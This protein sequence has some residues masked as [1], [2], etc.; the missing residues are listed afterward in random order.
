MSD[1]TARA[2]AL[3]NLLQTHRHWT[4]QELAERLGV[5]RRTLRRDV[6]R[7]RDL[8]YR[9]GSAPGL[10][11]G[12]RLEPGGVVP[13]LLLTDDEA[14]AMAAGLRLAAT[15]RLT[16]G[17]DTT[18]RALTKLERVLPAP[19]RERVNALAAAVRPALARPG[20]GVSPSVLTELAL[21]CRDHERVRF[22]H[23]SRSGPSSRQVEPHHLAP[24][25]RHWYLLCRDL[26]RDAW[27]TFRIDRIT[28]VRPTGVF[29][30]P[31]PLS[32]RQVE[33]FVAV[34]A[35]WAGQ[36]AEASATI[37]MPIGRLR[38]LFG[39]WAQGAAPAGPGTTVWQVGGAGFRETMYALSWL[40]AGVAYTADLPE[41][42]R[43]ELREV[44]ERMLRALETAPDARA[45]AVPRHADGR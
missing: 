21:A 29:F 34:A 25:E 8:G 20:A 15:R 31:Q 10:A 23:A 42:A 38:Q 9:I 2:L 1:T 4:G 5:S 43:S 18:I 7:L 41:P 32:P 26:D 36:P 37:R 28:D 27:R 35:S 16:D 30:E 33:E 45:G 14:V 39:E 19:L 40:P 13:P 22:T 3:L 11:G 17:T 12:Y 44:L 6:E 24:S